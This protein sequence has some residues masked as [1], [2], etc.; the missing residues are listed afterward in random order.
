MRIVTLFFAILLILIPAV[1]PAPA[2]SEPPLPVPEE[3]TA[4]MERVRKEFTGDLDQIKTRKLIRVLVSFSRTNFFFHNG[5]PQ[6]FEYEL[7]RAYEKF[8]NKSITYRHEGVKMVFV[9]VPFHRLFD[10]LAAGRGD[11]AAAGLTITS[12]R[13]AKVNFSRPYI[14]CVD[15]V[16]VAHK[17][18]PPLMGVASLSDK[19]VYIRKGSSYEKHLEA[20]NHEFEQKGLKPVKITIA[21]PYVV[22]EDILELINAGIVDLTV[23]DRHIA[24]AWLSALTD[25]VIHEDVVVN[26]GGKIAWAVRKENPQLLES[27]NAFIRKNRKGSYLG[28]ILFKRYYESSRWIDNPNTEEEQRKL[29]QVVSLFR[30]YGRQYEINYMAVAAQ[31]YQESKLDHSK[32][33]PIGAVGIMQVLPSTA[34]DPKVGISDIDRIENNIH[35]GIKYLDFLRDHYF[36]ADGISDAD[37]L[38]FSWA[39]Y[40]AGPAKINKLRRIARKRGYDPNQWF[41]NVEYIAAE[42]IGRETFDYV[43]NIYKYYVAYQLYFDL[44]EKR[45]KNKSGLGNDS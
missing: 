7:L 41:F 37:R 22:T 21:D 1:S 29:S 44:Y 32:V 14:S 26:S 36:S 10:D 33:S 39:A 31:A 38:Y 5:H 12:A 35:A 17:S 19:T 20:L 3:E 6:G 23:A 27:L 43:S 24:E 45:M 40:N 11:I 15:E 8:L 18:A 42:K 13:A 25:I 4:L 34:A 9:P 2:N 16:A 30:N 28:N